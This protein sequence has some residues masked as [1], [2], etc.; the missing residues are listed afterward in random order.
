MDIPINNYS[1]SL[2][3]VYNEYASKK[4]S[5]SATDLQ[6]RLSGDFSKAGTDELME[7]CK[8]FESYLTE[9]VFKAM[10]S[11][12]SLDGEYS[13]TTKSTM[14]YVNEML[15]QTYAK[16]STENNGLGIAQMLYEQMKRNYNISE[17]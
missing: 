12:V 11:T 17:E 13:S 14:Q 10:Q 9:Q 1:G 15:T 2:L 4:E 5:T 6:N 16:S 3:D 8:E 7:V